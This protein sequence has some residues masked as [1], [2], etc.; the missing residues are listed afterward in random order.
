MRRQA[1]ERLLPAVYQRVA[2]EGSVLYALLDVMEA[3]HA[4][5]EQRLAAVDD[6]F[7]PYRT[8]EDLVPFLARWTA[9]AQVAAVLPL[10]IG[11]RRDVVAESAS[12]A[13]LRGTA[14]GLLAYLEIATGVAG[15]RIEEPS[16]RPFHFV[17]RVPEGAENQVDLLRRIADLE[18]PAATTCEVVVD[19]GADGAAD[20]EESR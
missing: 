2:T 8:P 1:I 9:S 16:D 5:S 17:V 11:R 19:R 6:L 10:P 15:V 12:L 7:D 14:A 3:M 20:R 18:K 4:P 13:Q